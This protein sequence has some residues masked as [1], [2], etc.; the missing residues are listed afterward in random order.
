MDCP[1]F[2][3]ALPSEPR[4]LSVAR[5]FVEAVFSHPDDM[6]TIQKSQTISVRGECEGWQKNVVEISLCKV[7]AREESG[8]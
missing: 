4:M 6:K 2:T 7:V 1:A 8:K 3:L 5:T